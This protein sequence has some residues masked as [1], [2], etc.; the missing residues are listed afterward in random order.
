MD[1]SIYHSLN[2]FAYRHAWV[3]ELAKLFAIYAVFVP[4]ALVALIW[5]A[6]PGRARVPLRLGAFAAGVSLLLALLLVYLIARVYDRPRPFVHHP[7]HLL[8]AH[9]RDA[10]FPSDHTSVAFAIA[11]ALL[12][13]G[14]RALGWSTFV[15]AA[16]IGLARVM[17]GVHYPSDVLGGA[18][19]GFLAALIVCGGPGRALTARLSELLSGI[20]SRG[21]R[22]PTRTPR[23]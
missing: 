22:A 10:S 3:G 12:F 7:H 18:A 11:F 4:V 6:G 17:V 8:I 13:F 23:Q 19:V 1:L 9:G 5:L 20:Y 21:L 2:D 16:L 15:V 14:R